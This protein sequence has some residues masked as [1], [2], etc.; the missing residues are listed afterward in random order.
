MRNPTPRRRSAGFTLIELLVVIAILG[1]LGTVVLR[2]VWGYIDEAKQKAAYT[3]VMNIDQ[4]LQ[5]Y[6][7]KHNQ[8]PS[9][10]RILTEPDPANNNDPWIPE[11]M[12]TD[13]WDH[14][15]DL[16]V[17]DK[18]KFEVISYG[19]NGIQDGFDLELGLNRDI[20]S[21]HPLDPKDATT[22]NR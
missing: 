4:Q 14:P 8:L 16:K 6:K 1:I 9:D 17:D 10:L 5:M 7:R 2:N 11:E 22:G 12:L 15:I 18:G 20:G 21:H 13:P 3:K 19:E